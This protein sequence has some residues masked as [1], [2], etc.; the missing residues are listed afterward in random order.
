M[1]N[2]TENP[3]KYTKPYMILNVANTSHP[4]IFTDDPAKAFCLSCSAFLSIIAPRSPVNIHE[5]KDYINLTS[6]KLTI[7]LH[8]AN[9]VDIANLVL[10]TLLNRIW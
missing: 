7:I 1:H 8:I 4:W 6:I 2:I 10:D 9:I 5:G 3:K